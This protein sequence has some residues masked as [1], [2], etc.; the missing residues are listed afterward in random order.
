MPDVICI[1][2]RIPWRP[3]T[4]AASASFGMWR[5]VR[6]LSIDHHALNTSEILSCPWILIDLILRDNPLLAGLFDI[7]GV[8]G[9]FLF[10]FGNGFVYGLLSYAVWRI[11]K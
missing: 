7:N 3:C 4:I 5:A 6:F 2:Y 8:G 10:F 1:V 9:N 11:L